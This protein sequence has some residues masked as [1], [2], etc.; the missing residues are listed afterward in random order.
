MII[1]NVENGSYAA[2]YF[3][4]I[5]SGFIDEQKALKNSIYMKYND[6]INVSTVTFDQLKGILAECEMY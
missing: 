5:F 2:S 3:C 4:K 6:I 1:I